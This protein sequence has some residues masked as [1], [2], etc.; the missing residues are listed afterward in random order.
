MQMA[1]A[2]GG[3]ELPVAAELAAFGR[4]ADA[5]QDAISK[6]ESTPT[7]RPTAQN[8]LGF[9]TRDLLIDTPSPCAWARYL[10]TD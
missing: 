8:G 7:I 3:D 2:H 5:A 6:S 10:E 9:T 1:D 4:C